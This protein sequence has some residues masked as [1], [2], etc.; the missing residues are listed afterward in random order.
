[1][2][3]EPAEFSSMNASALTTLMET[4]GEDVWNYA[5]FLARNRAVADDIAQETFIRAYK[6]LHS[7]RGE[8]S[9]KT[10][11]L[12]IARNRWYSYR[13]TAFVRRVTLKETVG[14]DLAVESAEEDFLRQ[15]LS[16]EVWGLVLSLPRKYREVLILQA[17]YGLTMDELAQTLG[18][19]LSAAKSRLRRARRQMNDLWEKELT[20]E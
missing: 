16:G 19:S 7:F 3:S 11:L 10:W 15:S 4:Y 9:V 13:S 17:H 14:L 12:Q 20:P 5:Y 18:V 2:S 8:A 1:M 6:Y